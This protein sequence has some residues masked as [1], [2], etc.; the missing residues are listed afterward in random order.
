M[1]KAIDYYLTLNSP[2]AYLGGARL[3]R[4]AAARGATI[5]VKP[6][7]LHEIFPKTGGLPLPKRAPARQ[8]YRLAELKRWR[9]F[10]DIPLNLAPK[11]YPADQDLAARLVIAAGADGSDP[12]TLAHAVLRA[13]WAEERDIADE[14]TLRSILAENGLSEALM[15]QAQAQEAEAALD[16]LT[17]E[18]LEAGVFG[19][20]SYICD[21]ELFWGQDRLDFLE[22]ALDRP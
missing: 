1:A 6:M 7:K 10:L 3:E 21:G 18:A 11:F 9:A 12:L 15:V 16:A 17:A 20:P 13:I 2:W 4:I 19:A 8:A 14:A 22:R 5:R